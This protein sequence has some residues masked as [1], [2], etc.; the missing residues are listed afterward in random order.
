[1]RLLTQSNISHTIII[2][3]MLIISSLT[4]LTG[5][6]FIS[7]Q[8]DTMEKEI[9]ETKL[10]LEEHRLEEI[11]REVDALVDY[12]EFRRT[13]QGGEGTL[14]QERVI[15]WMSTVRFGTPKENYIFAYRVHDLQGGDAFAT[16]LVNPNRP[17]LV[18]ELIATGYTDAK[19]VPFRQLALEGI[20]EQGTAIVPYMYKKPGSQILSQKVTYFRHYAPWDWIIAAGAYMDDIDALLEQKREALLKD[21]RQD[22]TSTVVIFLFFTFIAYGLAIVLGKQIEH[23]FTQY[24]EEVLAKTQELQTLNQTLEQRVHEEISKNRAQE[25]LLIQKSKF[26]A[27]GEMISNIAHQWRQP[28]TE[29]SALLM[30]LKF[31]YLSQTL[32]PTIIQEKSK[33]AEHLIDYM[34]QTIDDFRH[35]FAPDKQKTVF[36]IIPR[37]DSVLT[38]CH[39]SLKNYHIHLRIKAPRDAYVR[40]FQNE[41]EQVLLNLITNAKD[42]LLLTK[43]KNPTITLELAVNKGMVS[44]HVKDNAGGISIEPIEKIFEPYVTTKSSSQGIGIGLYM[45]K[46]IIENNMQGNLIAR[47]SDEGAEFEVRLKEE[48]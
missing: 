16:M 18:G 43:P 2:A 39:A 42:A 23:F 31:H 29:L 4:F 21:T 35:F 5:Y 44:L 10:R 40:G 7:K 20:R 26:I 27:L 17:D 28:L 9:A 1:M 37:I 13:H 25:Q 47:N 38:I 30:G 14:L 6:F 11:K 48:V 32:N 19:G 15:A 34:S 24:R 41:Y 46:M 45:S 12:I 36:A 33:E 8:Y 22:I 3:S